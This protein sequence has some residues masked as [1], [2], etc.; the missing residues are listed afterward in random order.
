MSVQYSYDEHLS[1][2]GTYDPHAV[3]SIVGPISSFPFPAIYVTHH[4]NDR[5]VWVTSALTQTS[6]IAK[7][8]S[9]SSRIGLTSPSNAATC[10]LSIL[11][12]SS[13]RC[14]SLVDPGKE[15]FGYNGTTFAALWRDK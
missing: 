3:L 14:R 9:S 2:A 7:H 5:R 4:D 15:N 8:S 1:F 10:T 6:A 12:R 11:P 13:S